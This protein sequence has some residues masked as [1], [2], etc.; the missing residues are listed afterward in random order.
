[1]LYK[2]LDGVFFSSSDFTLVVCISGMGVYLKWKID[3]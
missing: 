1:M 3:V 2:V